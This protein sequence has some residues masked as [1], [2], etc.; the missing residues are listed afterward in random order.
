MKKLLLMALSMCVMVSFSYAQE[1][2]GEPKKE[3]RLSAEEKAEMRAYYETKVYPVKKAA[4][5]KMMASL[6]GEDREFLM[7]KQ[8]EKKSLKEQMRA[9]KKEVRQ[10][11]KSGADEAA[12][13]AKKKEVK[14]PLRAD[15]K[16]LKESMKPFMERNMKLIESQYA[17]IKDNKDLWVDDRERM[18]DEFLSDDAK[19]KRDAKKQAKSDKQAANPDKAAD[20]AAKKEQN[21]ML[22]FVLWDGEMKKVKEGKKKGGKRG[23]KKGKK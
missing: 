20:R 12:V 19:A 11:E 6:S 21:K 16:A 5:D 15:Y 14:K 1:G 13:K 17:T 7:S 4:Y 3:K 23:G 2:S 10:L 22:S 9:A 18:L 8:A